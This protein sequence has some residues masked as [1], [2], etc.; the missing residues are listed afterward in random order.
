[1]KQQLATQR[2]LRAVDASVHGDRLDRLDD[3]HQRNFRAALQNIA[4]VDVMPVTQK[5]AAPQMLGDLGTRSVGT[6]P[7]ARRPCAVAST[8]PW[9]VK[10][11]AENDDCVVGHATEGEAKSVSR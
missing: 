1:M 2:S 9:P 8:S 10:K 6:D 5:I 3:A 11:R 4:A 7:S